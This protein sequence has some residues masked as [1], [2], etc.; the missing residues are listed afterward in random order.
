[1]DEVGKVGKLEHAKDVKWNNEWT[2]KSWEIWKI[3][4]WMNLKQFETMELREKFRKLD[5]GW[6]QWKFWKLERKKIECRN[7]E[8]WT[9]RWK[10]K[11]LG[12]G[13]SWEV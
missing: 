3:R 12:N 1:M 2:W 4:K 13:W 6:T 10:L 8:K 5:N 9:T 7:C 11:G